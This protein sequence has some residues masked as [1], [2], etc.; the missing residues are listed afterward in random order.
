MLILRGGR[1]SAEAGTGRCLYQRQKWR[2]QQSPATLALGIAAF[3]DIEPARPTGC[4]LSASASKLDMSSTRTLVHNPGN[5]RY[6]AFN[7]KAIV[8]ERAALL[9]L[10]PGFA[11]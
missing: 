3:S 10:M 11:A 4:K 8:R 6:G 1:W 7:L 5:D 9:L 2:S